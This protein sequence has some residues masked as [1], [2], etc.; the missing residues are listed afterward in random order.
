MFKYG[1]KEEQITIDSPI[2][3]LP[4]SLLETLEKGWAGSFYTNV[5]LS[6]NEDRFSSM[7][8]QHYS[9][10]NRPVNILISLL[11]LKELHGLTDE[12]L[13]ASLYFDY[14]FQYALGISDIESEG[15]CINTLTNFRLRLLQYEVKHDEDLFEQEMKAL[16]DKLAELVG[17]NKS[18][19]RMDSFMVSSTCKKLSRL[20]L[21]YRVVTAMVEALHKQNN[22]LVPEAFQDFVK[23]GYRNTLLY[24][25]RSE[26]AGSKLQHLMDQASELYNHVCRLYDFHSTTAYQQ[27]IRLLQEQCIETE[28]GV[29]IAIE[30]VKLKPDGLQNPS[31]PN[32]TYRNKGGKGHVG[33]VTNIVEVRDTEKQMGLILD[34]DVQA[35]IH[36][37]ASSG[38]TF[39]K[40]SSLAEDIEVLAVD[41]A[42]YR[43]ETVK[44][45]ESKNIE[46]N[47]SNMTGRKA[48]VD[49]IP[50]TQ[51]EVNDEQVITACPAGHAPLR[52][53]YNQEK[54]VYKA[55]F[56]KNVCQTCPMLSTCPVQ[57]QMKNNT[58]RFTQ[59]KRQSDAI[60]SKHGTARHSEL[61]KF[62]AGV[63]GLVSALRRRYDVDNLPVFGLLR[64]KMWISA[65]I[66]AFNFNSVFKYQI[67]LG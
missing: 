42:Y 14:R 17:L 46:M 49:Q 61:S 18:M 1:R 62:R 12:Q 29:R 51:F 47:F 2:M 32:A 5:F 54:Q 8:S 43:E 34:F 19:A 23:E 64:S 20:E 44:A 40:E 53:S 28:E 7:Y 35:N 55:T 63:E 57:Q 30:G 13:I 10:P 45:A 56:D 3:Q 15:I 11:L 33:Y 25:T 60:R 58:V 48:S 67:R 41:G 50:V 16:S 22:D 39:V 31:D 6:V 27:L 59:S 52:S 66:G 37:D 65:K 24:H 9:R 4:K 21:V 26:E 38:E 36:S